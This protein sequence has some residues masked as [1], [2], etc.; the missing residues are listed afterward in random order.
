[1]QIKKI[2]K[3]TANRTTCQYKVTNNANFVCLWKIR[4]GIHTSLGKTILFF[5]ELDAF[6][7]LHKLAEFDWN[8]TDIYLKVSYLQVENGYGYWL[9]IKKF[10]INSH[11]H[12]NFWKD[13][14]T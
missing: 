6:G 5:H 13:F 9:M 14:A 11:K 8:Q 12:F 3:E 4:F 1:M 10:K 2:K 7:L